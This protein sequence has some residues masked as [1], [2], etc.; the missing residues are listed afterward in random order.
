MPNGEDDGSTFD[1]V[2]GWLRGVIEDITTLDV[3]TFSGTLTVDPGT[4]GEF[5]VSE[6]YDKL[7][8]SIGDESKLKLIALTHIDLDFDVTTFMANNLSS[9]E[10]ELITYHVSTVE[11]S[12]NARSSVVE[13]ALDVIGR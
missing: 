3:V 12:Q 13:L 8:G 2:T 6:L 7:K 10:K 4:E 9:D 11:A 1:K 5:K